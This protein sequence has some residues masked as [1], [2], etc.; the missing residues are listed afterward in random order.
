MPLIR[1]YGGL[2]PMT[3]ILPKTELGLAFR[4][5]VR[6]QR[7]MLVTIQETQAHVDNALRE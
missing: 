6:I 7:R 5:Y 3:Q 2:E 4:N 1:R